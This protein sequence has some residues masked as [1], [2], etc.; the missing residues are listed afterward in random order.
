MLQDF[1]P[2]ST[3]EPLLTGSAPAWLGDKQ[4]QLR[5]RSY[6][7]YEQIYTNV[8]SGFKLIEREDASPIY[9]PSARI[10]VE[11]MNRYM[12]N[13]M[14]LVLDPEMG[15]TTLQKNAQLWLKDFIRRERFYS[16]FSA[17]KRYGIM[18]GD[19]VFMIT[20]DPDRAEGSRVSV[21]CVDPASVFPIFATDEATG[22]EDPD[23]IIGWHIVEQFQDPTSDTEKFL[24]KRTTFRKSTGTGGPSPITY[25]VLVFET[26]DWGGPGQ[27][28]EPEI[29]SAIQPE[30]K[31]PA[32]IDQ[33]PVYHIPNTD[34]SPTGDMW[35]SSE[36]RGFE[37]LMTSIN[38]IVTDEDLTLIMD[39]LGVYATNAG[40]PTNPDG[41]DGKW[42]LGP[43]RVAELPAGPGIF[44]N[45]V[46]GAGNIDPYQTHLTYIHKQMDLAAG[47]PAIAKGDVEVEA[48]E[49][50]VALAIKY[51]PIISVA[52]EKEIIVTDKTTQ[53]MYGLSRWV[54]A[55]EGTAF[56]YLL[57]TQFVPLYG[58]KIPENKA[59]SFQEI[60]EMITNKVI[61]LA[62]GWDML[63][64]LGYE[65]PDNKTMLSAL[66][67]QATMEADIM[68][69]RINGEVNR[70][71]EDEE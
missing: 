10:I 62:T 42:N 28:D 66:Q 34:N 50:G 32:P 11:T 23:M 13:G 4:E 16:K 64:K 65:L 38:Q 2:Y 15:T 45:R 49:S 55:Y 61:D 14:N 47:Q 56:N 71:I 51:G 8:P 48:A 5:I 21:E 29:V 60:M 18:R 25:E 36:L 33:L 68:A 24:L 43:G 44:F 20:A 63:R 54:V 70:E 69:S 39:G 57:E 67:D 17:N 12:A 19:W 27:D 37:R 58:P 6:M 30:T 46:S 59:K 52:D 3:A 9:I 26:D 41:T 40:V 35:G 7:L 22:I 31:L 1:H 53:F